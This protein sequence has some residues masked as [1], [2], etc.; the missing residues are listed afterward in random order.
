VRHAVASLVTISWLGGASA[1]TADNQAAPPLPPTG[2]TGPSSEAG[3]RYP[4]LELLGPLR[5]V[6]AVGKCEYISGMT[7]KI[8]CKGAHPLPSR[9]Y[10]VE[11]DENGKQAG[12]EVR[13]LYPRLERGETGSAT[14]RIRLSSPTRVRLRGE[15]K[16]PW[17]NPY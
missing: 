6:F 11:F 8:R 17:Q 12:A 15:W 14:F 4:T 7:C 16:G 5:D 10:F 3:F 13:L 1:L 2:Q 9:V